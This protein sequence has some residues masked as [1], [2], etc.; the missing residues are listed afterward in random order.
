M[1]F[2]KRLVLFPLPALLSLACAISNLLPIGATAT[3]TIT[4]TATLTLTPT[5]TPTLAPTPTPLP[6]A[7]IEEGDRLLFYGEWENAL[8]RYQSALVATADLE[9]QTAALLGIGRT[10]YLM[11]D[12]QKAFETLSDLVSSYPESPHTAHAYFFLA[13]TLSALG[14]H[15]QAA[16]AYHPVLQRSPGVIDSYLYEAPGDALAAGGDYMGAIQSYQQALQSPRAVIDLNI[17]IKIARSY[18][19][20]GDYQTAI[21]GYQDIY[22]P[23]CS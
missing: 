16:E 7:R 23:A 9:V 3:P 21:I 5:M 14:E 4:A 17:D 13:R 12:Y 18:A 2:L 20:A 11:G 1:K 10:Y 22:N 19:L 8:L 6:R 15:L